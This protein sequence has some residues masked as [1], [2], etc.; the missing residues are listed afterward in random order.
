M[1]AT[2]LYVESGTTYSQTIGLLSFRGFLE[3]DHLRKVGVV[4][5]T[6]DGGVSEQVRGFNKIIE[7]RVSPNTTPTQ[8]RFLANWITSDDKTIAF[9]LGGVNPFISQVINDKDLESDWLYDC[10]YGREFTLELI[11]THLYTRWDDG[12]TGEDLMYCKLAIEMSQDATEASPEVFTTN[13]GKLVVMENGDPFPS[14]SSATHKFFVHFKSAKGS[15]ADYP[16]GTVTES[17]GNLTVST[18]PASNY[19]LN[20]AGKL[21]ANFA[22]WLQPI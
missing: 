2:F 21:I 17:G 3:P 22:I 8:R 18:F 10:E 6:L 19:T 15:S 14:F 5:E 4:H 13:A 16:T 12:I 7:P 11:D 1:D 20:V 9:G